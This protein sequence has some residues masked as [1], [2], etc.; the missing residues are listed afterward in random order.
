[1]KKFSK[2]LLLSVLSIFLVA[3]TAMATPIDVTSLSLTELQGEFDRIGSSIDASGVGHDE[4][5]DELFA[6][7]SS[8]STATYVATVSWYQ[9]YDLQFG[10]YDK[11]D[12]NERLTLFDTRT[13]WPLAGD[14]AQ[15][16]IDLVDFDIRSYTMPSNN[17][18]DTAT[19]ASSDFGFYIES[20]DYNAGTYFSESALNSSGNDRFLT[21]MGKGDYVD[22]DDSGPLPALNDLAHWYIAAESGNYNLPADL[23]FS[24]FVVQMESVQPVPE[25]ATMLLFGTGLLGLAVIGRK[26]FF[27]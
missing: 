24:D 23:D 4:T 25:P 18:I 3:G 6:F 17:T 12:T 5:Q 20:F 11:Y 9:G 14:D 7:Q 16:W 13:G 26:K 15:I 27:K 10:L 19:F 2:I 21:Y 8:G 22:M 1:M